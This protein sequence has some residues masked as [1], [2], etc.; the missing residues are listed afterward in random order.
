[1]TYS[2]DM[3]IH[4][5]ALEEVQTKLYINGNYV[6]SRSG[7][8]GKISPVDGCILPSLCSAS[9][10]DLN[11]AIKFAKDVFNKGLWRDTSR[12][13]KKKRL[14]H[15][16]NLVEQDIPNLAFLDTIETGRCYK[17]FVEDS[18]PKAVKAIRWFSEYVDKLEGT[19]RSN[20]IGQMC[21]TTREPLGVVGIIL[22]WNDPLVVAMW[23][24]IPA[25]LMGNSI[26]IKPSEHAS[27][28]ILRLGDF[29]KR[30]GIPDGV[31]NILPGEGRMLGGAISSSNS[32]DGVFFTGSTETAKLIMSSAG[33][34]NLKRLGLECGGK[35]PFIVSKNCKN[36]DIAV[37]TLAKN[38]FYNQGQICSAPSR[39]LIDKQ[40]SKTFIKKLLIEVEK[41]IPGDPFDPKTAVGAICGEKNYQKIMQFISRAEKSGIKKITKDLINYPHSKGFYIAPTIFLDPPLGSEIEQE[42]VF[43]PVL[44]IQ[45]FDSISEASILANSTKYGL[46]AA[47]WSD[48]L[49]EALMLSRMLNAGIVHIN[50][51]GDDDEGAPFGGIKQSGIGKDKSK[52]AFDEYSN[53]KTIWINYAESQ[54]NNL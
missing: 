21:I 32:I 7:S 39:L 23:K 31:I 10:S 34:S 19:F 53:L 1:M 54:Q 18:I 4:K 48:D 43:G 27:Y 20:E 22:P 30:S 3:E 38:M 47:V 29:F 52:M 13:E 24:I 51:Y 16:A 26:I 6:S 28:S 45:E 5:I 50:S 2:F 11:E 14:F 44:T 8:I 12:N 42:E 49:K 9:E 37:Q 41:Y 25:I 35:S 15:F 46:A 33:S 36:L 17:N 40:I